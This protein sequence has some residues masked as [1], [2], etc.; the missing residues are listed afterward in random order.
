MAV[1]CIISPHSPAIAPTS[2]AVNRS[3]L[4]A[5]ADRTK[6]TALV[7]WLDS[8]STRP[9]SGWQPWCSAGDS[10]CESQWGV[11]SEA[12]LRVVTQAS[13]SNKR[14]WEELPVSRYTDALA[15]TGAPARHLIHC[16]PHCTRGSTLYRNRDIGSTSPPGHSI[17]CKTGLRGTRGS[18]TSQYAFNGRPS[19]RSSLMLPCLASL[20]NEASSICCMPAIPSLH[21]LGLSMENSGL[22]LISSAQQLEIKCNPMGVAAFRCKTPCCGTLQRVYEAITQQTQGSLMLEHDLLRTGEN[23]TNR[24]AQYM[25]AVQQTEGCHLHSSHGSHPI[26]HFTHVLMNDIE[27]LVFQKLSYDY[28]LSVTIFKDAKNESTGRNLLHNDSHCTRRKC[29]SDKSREDQIICFGLFDYLPHNTWTWSAN[30]DEEFL[31]RVGMS[32]VYAIQGLLASV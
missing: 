22:G 18:N 10:S 20:S 16:M 4:D 25:P 14:S 13:F 7:T 23:I 21:G 5:S 17:V 26:H 28:S 6:T 9:S 29:A 8:A 3:D 19:Y 30:A 31:Q 15:P 27:H 32:L 24:V 12:A 1:P 2:H 11:W